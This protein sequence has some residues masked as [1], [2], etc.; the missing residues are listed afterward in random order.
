METYNISKKIQIKFQN[1]STTEILQKH[2]S[3]N[4]S[5]KQRTFSQFYDEI[6]PEN[7]VE[8]YQT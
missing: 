8:K 7:R 1:F 6:C 2:S 3:E 5:G 4:I